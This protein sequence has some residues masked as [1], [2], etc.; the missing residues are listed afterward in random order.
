MNMYHIT[1]FTLFIFVETHTKYFIIKENTTIQQN[2][3]KIFIIWDKKWEKDRTCT[4]KKNRGRVR[5]FKHTLDLQ[6]YDMG[7]SEKLEILYFSLNL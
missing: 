2:I 3:I 5:L 1:R 7:M 6:L 4:Y